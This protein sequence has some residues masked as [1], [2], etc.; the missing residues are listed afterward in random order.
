MKKYKPVL[1]GMLIG[2]L[3]MFVALRYHVVRHDKGV[4]LVPRSPQPPL[5]SVYS[6][7]RE[8]GNAMW[9]QHPEV[10]Q[11]L[12]E[13]EQVDVISDEAIDEVSHHV[14]ETFRIGS[15]KLQGLVSEYQIERAAI[16]EVETT[17]VSAHEDS[18]DGMTIGRFPQGLMQNPAPN[19]QVP[20]IEEQTQNAPAA[21]QPPQQQFRNPFDFQ[22]RR[23]GSPTVGADEPEGDTDAVAL[24][25]NDP[26]LRELGQVVENGDAEELLTSIPASFESEATDADDEA[27]LPGLFSSLISRDGEAMHGAAGP[28]AQELELESADVT[29]AAVP[30]TSIPARTS[31]PEPEA[32][33]EPII[34]VR[35]F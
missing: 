3:L 22:P 35:P 1:L 7:V 8:W 11:A 25:S 20:I 23:T 26:W 24:R 34:Q 10:A 4:S 28:L 29:Q 12:I 18:H 2:S 30:A 16:A 5:R 32:L 9:E 15:E 19:T 33:R 17:T 14:Q 13:N 21:N 31:I 27:W 6:D